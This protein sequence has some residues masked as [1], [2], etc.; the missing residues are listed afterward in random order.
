MATIHADA[1]HLTFT[2][3]SFAVRALGGAIAA[4][5]SSSLNA[6]SA[7]L[8]PVLRVAKAQVTFPTGNKDF[9]VLQA[10]PA[11]ISAEEAD[12][13]LMADYFGPTASKGV[14]KHPDDYEVPWHPHRGSELST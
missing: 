13:F 9:S 3:S 8:L 1:Q 12:P 5:M 11:A 4:T 6:S 2:T 7:A 10:F 14:A